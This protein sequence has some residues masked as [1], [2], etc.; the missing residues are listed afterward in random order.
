MPVPPINS[1]FI[2]KKKFLLMQRYE[3]FRIFASEKTKKGE[4]LLN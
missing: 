1:I 3:I 2:T 4:H